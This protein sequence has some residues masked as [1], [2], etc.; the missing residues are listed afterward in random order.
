LRREYKLGNDIVDFSSQ[1]AQEKHLDTR[2]LARVFVAE[3]IEAILSAKNQSSFLWALWSAKE[4]AFKACQKKNS[5]LIFSPKMFQVKMTGSSGTLY[6][7]EQRLDLQWSWPSPYVVHCCAILT[8]EPQVF[9]RWN[10]IYQLIGKIKTDP[11][12]PITYGQQSIAV[13]QELVYFLKT[14][15]EIEGDLS[16]RRPEIK[17]NGQRKKGPPMLFDGEMHCADYD[18]SLSHDHEWVAAVV[19][20]S[21]RG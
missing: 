1:E 5:H 19:R 15:F 16:V 18:I 8:P 7:E 9:T 14:K 20:D 11:N 2:F 13:R 10:E 3:E 17:I 4:A 21:A 6:Y 12:I